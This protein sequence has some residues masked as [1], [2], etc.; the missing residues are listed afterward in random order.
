MYQ[1]LLLFHEF[2]RYY[3]Y[4]EF[5][6]ISCTI[7]LPLSLFSTQQPYQIPFYLYSRF[8]LAPLFFASSGVFCAHAQYTPRARR[9]KP[10]SVNRGKIG[11]EKSARLIRASR[12]SFAYVFYY[13]E[14]FC[15]SIDSRE[16]EISRPIMPFR[17]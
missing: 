16:F 3:S 6:F 14:C 11:K 15:P 10:I 12:V 7:P 13:D 5:Q 17:M 2:T 9:S 4:N 1:S 8:Q